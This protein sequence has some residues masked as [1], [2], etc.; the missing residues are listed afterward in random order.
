MGIDIHMPVV[1]VGT[2]VLLLPDAL[3]QKPML[4]RK[5][6]TYMRKNVKQKQAETHSQS[7]ENLKNLARQD[8]YKASFKAATTEYL[9]ALHQEYCMT[10]KQ[11]YL[12]KVSARTHRET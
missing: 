9:K 12:P 11:K 3:E 10:T 1:K 7:L 8:L 6:A 4:S 2:L 5:R